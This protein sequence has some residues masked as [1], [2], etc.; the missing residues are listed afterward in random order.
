MRIQILQFVMMSIFLCTGIAQAN[1]QQD[2]AITVRA[3]KAYGFFTA[4]QG[5]SLYIM[6]DNR[7]QAAISPEVLGSMYQQLETQFGPQQSRGDWQQTPAEGMT[8]CYID[9]HFERQALCFQVVFDN[10]GLI[11]GL[12]V[13]PA[14]LPAVTSSNTVRPAGVE[15]LDTVLISGSFRLPATLSFPRK[16]AETGRKIPCLVLVHGSGPHDR[17]ETIGPNKL[18]REIAWEL[19][20]K[21]I[22]VLRYDK[23]TYVYGNKYVPEGRDADY[24][25]ETVDD[26][27]SAVAFAQAWTQAAPDSIFLLG[28]SLGGMLAPR[29]AERATCLAGAILLAAPARPLEDL[30]LEQVSYLNSI[31]TTKEGLR[32]EDELGKQVK[33]VKLL[34]TP[35][36]CN[37]IPLPLGLPA[38]YWEYSLAYKPLETAASL[39]IPLLVLQGERDYQVTM[40]D[41]NLWRTGLSHNSNAIFKSYPELNHML[42]QGHG[43]SVPNEYQE[44]SSVP[45]YV[46]DDMACFIHNAHL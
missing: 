21:D 28:H 12:F 20:M 37:T 5:D 19:A 6:M 39:S 8:V 45:G 18:F 16:A 26:A 13:R 23:R 29:I 46:I 44:P 33:N 2:E 42:Q 14:Q 43:K 7:M 24:D 3:E 10:E 1:A 41:F 15:E 31:A 36:F 34:G 11:A 17:D 22:A 35:A 9:M 4:G 25:V 38:S 32:Q 40:T 30:L 27:V